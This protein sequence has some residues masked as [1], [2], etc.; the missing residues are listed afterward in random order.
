[1]FVI[2][3]D[4]VG[5]HWVMNPKEKLTSLCH[6]WQVWV[7]VNSSFFQFNNIARGNVEKFLSKRQRSKKNIAI[8]KFNSQTK[9]QSIGS[10]RF[11][12]K[13]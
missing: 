5:F 2:E 8:A 11:K 1:M 3:K 9:F 10:R 13:I 4:F 12:M 7:T 6:C